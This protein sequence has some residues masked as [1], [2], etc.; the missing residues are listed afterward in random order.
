M[1]IPSL[2]RSH[3][4][5]LPIAGWDKGVH[6][7]NKIISLKVNIKTPLELELVYLETTAT[8]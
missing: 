6:A 4:I 7:F 2:Q 3:D 1:L 5:S 8:V